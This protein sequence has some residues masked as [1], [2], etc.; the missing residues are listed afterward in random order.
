[1]Q[2][3]DEVAPDSD[4]FLF[5]FTLKVIITEWRLLVNSYFMSS[6]KSNIALVSELFSGFKLCWHQ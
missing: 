1:M 2:L 4:E 5:F 6:L 3:E